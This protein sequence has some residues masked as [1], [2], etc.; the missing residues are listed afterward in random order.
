M[1]RKQISDFEILDALAE[2]VKNDSKHTIAGIVQ[3]YYPGAPATVDVLV[4]V[5][6]ARFDVDTDE[7][8]SEPG[9]T[10]SKVPV[11]YPCGGGYSLTFPLANGDKVQL[12][13]DDLDPTKHRLTGN[14]EDPIDVRRHAGRYW[15]AVPVDFTISAPSAGATLKIGKGATTI[16]ID[17]S[18][19]NLAGN[20]DFVALASKVDACMASIKSHTH[21]VATTGS[22]TAQTGTAAASPALSSLPATGS[23]IVKSG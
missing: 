7:R 5:N 18:T 6:D 4:A 9:P 10:L 3:A 1:P 12:I 20:S 16:E 19:I 11:A 8:I 17:G 21:P 14:Q 22:A 13:A 15:H 2:R 23:A